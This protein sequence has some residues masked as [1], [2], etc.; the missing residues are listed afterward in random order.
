MVLKGIWRRTWSSLFFVLLCQKFRCTSAPGNHWK[1]LA[2]SWVLCLLARP[3]TLQC[4][5]F[6]K[7]NVFAG[8]SIIGTNKFHDDKL[9]HHHGPKLP[10]STVGKKFQRKNAFVGFP[11]FLG[12]K[13]IRFRHCFKKNLNKNLI[14]VNFRFIVWKLGGFTSAINFMT[15]KTIERFWLL[16]RFYVC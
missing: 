3:R 6:Q 16:R 2:P 14:Y 7:K 12:P 5:I 11:P 9:P 1:F 4:T 15:L 8:N 10:D 13:N